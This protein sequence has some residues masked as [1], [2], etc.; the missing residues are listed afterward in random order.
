MTRE[1]RQHAVSAL[2]AIIL[3]LVSQASFA[4]EC[5]AVSVNHGLMR[6]GSTR[7]I[8]FEFP[9]HNLND[10]PVRVTVKYHFD[11]FAM[12]GKFPMRKTA[13]DTV[14]FDLRPDEEKRVATRTDLDPPSA[15]AD[16]TGMANEDSIKCT[17]LRR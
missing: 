13:S 6:G 7:H 10:R 12:Y 2:Y 3:C 17:F 14:T 15:D 16:Y 4:E 1:T 5:D 8:D 9:V 11:Y